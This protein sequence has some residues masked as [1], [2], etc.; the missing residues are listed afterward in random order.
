MKNINL[1]SLYLNKLK[2][3]DIREICKLKNSFWKYG[4]NNNLTWFKKNILKD[5]IHIILR[6]K[7]KIIGYNLLRKRN[8]YNN[9]KKK[10]YYYFD[11]LIIDKDF[12]K[13]KLS[14]KILKL[15]NS[16]LYKKKI[17]G[18]LICKKKS[19]NFYKKFN[20]K[21]IKNTQFILKD[22]KFKKNLFIGMVNNYLRLDIKKKNIYYLKQINK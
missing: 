20:W 6:Y 3:N 8:F 17:H 10:Y 11:T 9:S 12:R 16:I 1:Q 19:E 18:F 22:H 7:K 13:L 4:L 15:N 21:K 14:K 2:K 5:D